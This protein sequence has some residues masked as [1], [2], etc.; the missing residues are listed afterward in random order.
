MRKYFNVVA[1]AVLALGGYGHAQTGMTAITATNGISVGGKPITAGKVLLTPV[2]VKGKPIAF[3]SGAGGGLNAPIAFSCNIAAGVLTGCHVPDACLTTPP[4]L[5]YTIDVT[6][7]AGYLTFRLPTVANICG[8]TWALDAYAPPSVTT[9]TQ[10]VQLTYGATAPPNPCATPSFYYQTSIGLSVCVGG[11][12]VAVGGG[13]VTAAA[14]VSA[15]AGRTGC[16]TAG[17]AWNPATDTCTPSSGSG[18]TGQTQGYAVEAAN[19]T[20]ATAS[21]PLDDEV[22]LTGYVTLHK[23]LQIIGT[24]TA[25]GWRIPEGTPIAGVSGKAAFYPDSTTHRLMQN[26]NNIGALMIPGM[27]TAG[28]S[29]HLVTL[30]T[31]GID[32]LDGGAVPTISTAL[33]SNNIPKANGANS[34]TNSS[35]ADDG[36]KVTVAEPLFLSGSSNGELVLTYTGS[37]APSPPA[38]SVQLTVRGAVAT[39]YSVGMPTAQGTGALTNDGAGNMSWSPAGSGALVNITGLVTASGCTVAGSQCVVGS[40]TSNVTFSSIPGGYTSL[41]IIAIYNGTTAGGSTIAAQ[42][43]GDTAA[44]YLW[45]QLYVT[46]TSV[47]TADGGGLVDHTQFGPVAGNSGSLSSPGVFDLTIPNYANTTFPKLTT[48]N[49]TRW[50]TSSSIYLQNFTGMWQ[51][52]AAITSIRMYV[53]FPANNLIAGS[54]FSIYG[55]Q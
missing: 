27:A 44:H 22:T 9:N 30:A 36:T 54:I 15:L 18:L 14:M 31:N 28:I 1:I 34:I 16:T 38:N 55:V 39:P 25:N 12:P 51:S 47:N 11:V 37:P 6:A 23:N 8:S 41:K 53:E 19:G 7:T 5:L 50:L 43:N 52:T 26:P 21:F 48:A 20:T 24:G 45:Q 13:S 4:N 3:V 32:L 29:G 42:F 17:N 49:G 35:L 46:G 33:T 10:T 2:D 40:N